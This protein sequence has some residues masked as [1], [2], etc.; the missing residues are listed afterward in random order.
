MAAALGGQS[1]IGV[2]SYSIGVTFCVALLKWGHVVVDAKGAG[3]AISG[4]GVA[5][6]RSG[7]APL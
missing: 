6:R 5:F 4:I 7:T 3:T 1:K 2:V